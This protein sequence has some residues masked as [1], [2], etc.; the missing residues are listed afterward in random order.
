MT[1]MNNLLRL[2]RTYVL[3]EIE[4]WPPDARTEALARI[5]E[6]QYRISNTIV[7]DESDEN[8]GLN[9]VV[10]VLM[11]DGRIVRVAQVHLSKVQNADRGLL[12]AMEQEPPDDLSSLAGPD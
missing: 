12:D 5:D 2:L 3:D 8:W 4:S 7:E 10:D 9:Y 6:G 11:N 1:V